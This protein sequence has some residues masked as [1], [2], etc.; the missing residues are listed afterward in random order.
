MTLQCHIL[1]SAINEHWYLRENA[2]NV[3]TNLP[4][5]SHFCSSVLLYSAG[6][7]LWMVQIPQGTRPHEHTIT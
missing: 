7:D 5:Y 6:V 1:P 3:R 4:A 2:A